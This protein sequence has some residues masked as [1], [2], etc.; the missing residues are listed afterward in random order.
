MGRRAALVVVLVAVIAGS[1]V[2][3]LRHRP[4][5]GSGKARL[6][7]LVGTT[8]GLATARAE[9]LDATRTLSAR[10]AVDPADGGAAARL[11]EV[12]LRRARVDANGG[13][14]VEAERVLTE[15]LRQ[16][17]GDYNALRALGAVY[18]SQHR[19]SEAATSARRAIAV[20]PLD[21][22]NFGVLG[23]ALVELGDRER[24]FD[25]FDAMVRMRPD[26][27][28]Y[29][30]VAY[31]QELQGR[32]PDALRSMRMAV[33][34]TS[35]RDP[36]SLAWHHAQIGDLLLQAGDRDGAAQAFA[37]AEF[38]FPGHP[39]AAAGRARV[40]AR[41]ADPAAIRQGR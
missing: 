14:A 3:A 4:V 10:L 28:A 17:P 34:A 5:T 7:P 38:V 27:A 36:E 20:R 29:A 21:A 18:L 24:A 33:E 39:D 40:A 35:P 25:A 6:T 8:E 12:Y 19:F 9:L 11:A 1:A 23:D 16:E 31:A 2:A 37:H 13:Y 15:V 22:W 30:R 32:I 26:A 41:T